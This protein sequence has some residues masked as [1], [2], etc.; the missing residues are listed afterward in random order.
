MLAGSLFDEE[1]MTT[2]SSSAAGST[3]A[4]LQAI[5]PR[6]V[7]S[8]EAS[9]SAVKPAGP[10]VKPGTGVNVRL[11]LTVLSSIPTNQSAP[12]KDFTTVAHDVRTA[13]DAGYDK[14]G[15][16]ADIYTTGKEVRETV[17]YD[18][19]DR[20]ELWAIASNEGGL[21]SKLE[22]RMALSEN[23]QRTTALIN[24]ASPLGTNSVAAQKAVLDY[25][26]D[27][28]PKKKSI[29]LPGAHNWW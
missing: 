4:A 23:A 19:L 29:P 17:G 8:A 1:Q 12:A 2:I 6:S 25:L 14:L 5:Q 3:L 10:T 15:K 24:N 22:Q 26:N 20:R 18:N 28:S 9:A 27:A 11:D 7:A 16:V 21:F 13:V